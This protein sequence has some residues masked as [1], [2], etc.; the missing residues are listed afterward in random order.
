MDLTVNQI[1]TLLHA[2][3]VAVQRYEEQRHVAQH[4]KDIVSG[5][6]CAPPFMAQRYAQSVEDCDM[7]I[8]ALKNLACDLEKRY[9]QECKK[10]E[11]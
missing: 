6:L 10:M 8:L 7:Q 1:R 5:F 2:L 4:Q 9:R 11:D 3:E